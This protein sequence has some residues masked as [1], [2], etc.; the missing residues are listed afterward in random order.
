[1]DAI[2]LKKNAATSAEAGIVITHATKMP[3][4]MPQRTA[5]T[6]RAAPTPMIAPVIV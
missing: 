5:D 4:A 2:S 3:R 6:R 1:M